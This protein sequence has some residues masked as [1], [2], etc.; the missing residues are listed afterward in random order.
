MRQV[1]ERMHPFG[2]VV[3]PELLKA[4]AQGAPDRR[5]KIRQPSPGDSRLQRVDRVAK[6]PQRVAQVRR[7]ETAPKPLPP[8]RSTDARAPAPSNDRAGL[9]DGELDELLRTA[10]R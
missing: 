3:A 1:A 9:P 6:V 2:L 8:E 10:R 4:V 5:G 7:S